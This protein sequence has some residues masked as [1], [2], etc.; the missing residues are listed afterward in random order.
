MG[1]GAWLSM[2]Q[3]PSLGTASTQQQPAAPVGQPSC[4][5]DCP[6]MSGQEGGMT[7]AAAGVTDTAASRSMAAIKYFTSDKGPI[8][9]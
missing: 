1:L 2:R 7:P 3:R 5:A 4:P 8:S 6:D 9:T